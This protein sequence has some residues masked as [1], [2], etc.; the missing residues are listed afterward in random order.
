MKSRKAKESKQI[1]GRC[2][3][4]RRK[5]SFGEGRLYCV[6]C[7]LKRVK[8]A[9]RLETGSDYASRV[10]QSLEDQRDLI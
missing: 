7:R 4:C 6:D 2:K 5:G 1:T 8:E 9:A 3:G 10:L